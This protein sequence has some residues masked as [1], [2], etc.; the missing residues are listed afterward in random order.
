M[1]VGG[2]FGFVVVKWQKTGGTWLLEEAVLAH[3]APEG[4]ATHAEGLCGF[5][6]PPLVGLESCSKAL[7]FRIRLSGGR[8]SP[9]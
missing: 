6:A 7:G 4:R 1:K 2:T 8:G 5:G 9:R 3:F